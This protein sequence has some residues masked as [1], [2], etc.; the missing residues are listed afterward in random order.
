MPNSLELFQPVSLEIQ[1]VGG[2]RKGWAA[3]RTS[4]EW[5]KDRHFNESWEGIESM[6]TCLLFEKQV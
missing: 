2:D 6:K 1:W 5:D 4:R 3:G